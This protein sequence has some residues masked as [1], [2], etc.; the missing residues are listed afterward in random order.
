MHHQSPEV[1]A[2]SRC[3]WKYRRIDIRLTIS[4]CS[5]RFFF[6]FHF[7]LASTYFLLRSHKSNVSR[8]QLS[9]VIHESNSDPHI[10]MGNVC[11][12]TLKAWDIMYCWSRIRSQ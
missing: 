8:D 4:A 7:S 6:T 12:M 9:L 2:D 3:V 5:V 1:Y 11:I 10:F